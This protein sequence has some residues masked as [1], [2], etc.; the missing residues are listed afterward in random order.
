MLMTA[1]R[2]S[3][4][5]LSSGRMGMRTQPAM[6]SLRTPSNAA[7]VSF[8]GFLDFFL[9]MPNTTTNRILV[10]TAGMGCLNDEGKFEH[11]FG[12]IHLSGPCNRS[13]YF[14]I[15]QHMMA[16]DKENNLNHIPKNIG[17][18][19]RECMDRNVREI[20]MTS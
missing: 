11:W 14:C 19:L 20:C 6:V 17:K 4:H 9:A 7:M 18:F 12:N 16:L 8:E 5:A 1:T 13:C 10:Y 2:L 3:F 15:G